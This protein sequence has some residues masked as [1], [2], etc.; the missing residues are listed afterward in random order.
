MVV[1]CTFVFVVEET[2]DTE[3]DIF[4]CTAD[5]WTEY[6]IEWDDVFE[7]LSG[8]RVTAT[9][10]P[11]RLSDDGKQLYTLNHIV[12]LQVRR[13]PSQIRHSPPPSFPCR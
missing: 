7:R 6:E 9:I 3:M 11:S 8:D 1:N 12:T 4:A 2:Q 10:T 5:D 13:L